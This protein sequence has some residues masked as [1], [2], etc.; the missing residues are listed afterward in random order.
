MPFTH[1]RSQPMRY[2]DVCQ[3]QS[4]ASLCDIKVERTRIDCCFLMSKTRWGQLHNKP[5]GVMYLDLT[6]HQP[7]NCKLAEATITMNF[8]NTQ[9]TRLLPLEN[10]E[11]T[12][13]FGPSILSGEKRERQISTTL[14]VNPKVGTGSS[15][16]EGA[17]WSQRSDTSY[18][19]RWRFTGS[20]F[21]A[22]PSSSL[23]A[24]NSRSSRYQQL[25]W[26]LEENELENQAIHH[27][28]VHSAVAFHHDSKPFY[29]DLQIEVK[30]HRWHH[31]LK[32][33]LICPPRSRRVY[34]RAKIDATSN[35][36][37]D[38][39]FVQLARNL[40]HAMIDTNLHPVVGGFTSSTTSLKAF[41]H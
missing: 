41:N 5:S 29:L 37:P 9:E 23:D 27:S 36:A 3:A 32:Q 22:E 13:F 10:I 15:N 33:R 30:L 14:E 24:L 21:V 20:R 39:N 1:S 28:T 31:R 40:D 12:E 35:V 38:P 34:T 19:S 25:V 18:A 8:Q 4:S 11:V 26:H 16:I 2:V 17:G 7:T 6:F